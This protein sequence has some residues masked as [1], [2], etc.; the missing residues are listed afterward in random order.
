MGEAGADDAV[1]AVDVDPDAE[2]EGGEAWALWNPTV[3]IANNDQPGVQQGIQIPQLPAVPQDLLNLDLSGSSMRF[4][5]ANGPNIAI[6]E[7][8]QTDLEDSSSSSDATS[9][10]DI[11][12]A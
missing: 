10:P 12:R 3:F 9:L 2:P 7:V 11:E 6:D 5:R 4:L 1:D 8:F